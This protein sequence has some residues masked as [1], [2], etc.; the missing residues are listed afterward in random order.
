MKEINYVKL[1]SDRMRHHQ[2]Y[3]RRVENQQR[4]LVC[5]ECGGSGEWKEVVIEETGEGPMYNCGICE[6]TGL[7]TPHLRGLWLKWKREEKQ[8]CQ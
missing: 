1:D 6:G 5:Q 7:L 2:R 8:K 3:R 4:K